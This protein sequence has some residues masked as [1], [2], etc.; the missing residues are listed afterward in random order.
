MLQGETRKIKDIRACCRACCRSI[1]SDCLDLLLSLFCEHQRDGEYPRADCMFLGT[2]TVSS[3]LSSGTVACGHFHSTAIKILQCF[4]P[5]LL[6]KK[7]HSSG[8]IQCRWEAS[9]VFTILCKATKLSSNLGSDSNGGRD[10]G[11]NEW[12]RARTLF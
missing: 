5:A 8:I 6:Q 12:R 9:P 2:G 11:K 1:V 7:E 3:C 4:S 10:I